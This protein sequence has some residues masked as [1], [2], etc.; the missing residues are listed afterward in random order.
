MEYV[1][2]VEIIGRVGSIRIREVSGLKHA[3]ISVAT[4]HVYKNNEG[5]V[6]VETDWHCVKAFNG[7]NIADLD[8]IKVADMLYI[9]GRLKTQCYIDSAGIE[10]RNTEIVASKVMLV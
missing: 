3:T 8:K 10:R 6:Y 7:E 4:E 1:N 5:T 9:I 2:N